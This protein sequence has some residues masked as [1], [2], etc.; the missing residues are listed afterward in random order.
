M[1][2]EQAKAAQYRASIEAATKNPQELSP[3]RVCLG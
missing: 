2:G 1:V 3:R